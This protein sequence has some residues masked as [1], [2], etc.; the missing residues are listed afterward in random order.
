[1]YFETLT[2]PQELTVHFDICVYLEKLSVTS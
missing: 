1:M 2:V